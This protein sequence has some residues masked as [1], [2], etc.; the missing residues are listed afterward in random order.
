MLCGSAS[1]S[2]ITMLGE[3]IHESSISSHE[4]VVLPK[5]SIR[6]SSEMV[7][8]KIIV[9][10]KPPSFGTPNHAISLLLEND[11]GPKLFWQSVSTVNTVF[12]RYQAKLMAKAEHPTNNNDKWAKPI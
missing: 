6:V 4:T 7:A 12:T 5:F 9:G 1:D 11:N 3:F 8:V 10:L 2:Y